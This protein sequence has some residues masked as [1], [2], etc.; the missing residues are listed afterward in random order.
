M[1]YYYLPLIFAY[2]LAF[3]EGKGSKGSDNLMSV[4]QDRFLSPYIYPLPFLLAVPAHRFCID[5]YNPS[6]LQLLLEG[7]GNELTIF[8][9]KLLANTL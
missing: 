9:Q 2:P 7:Y 4:Y 6:F 3:L 8:C 1:P 5:W